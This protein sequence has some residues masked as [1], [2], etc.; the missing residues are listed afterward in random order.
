MRFSGFQLSAAALLG[1]VPALVQPASAQGTAITTEDATIRI[2]TV[3]VQ[4]NTVTVS[5]FLTRLIGRL[6]TGQVVFDQSYAAAFGS[7]AV[8]GALSSV[9][10]AIASEGGP[11]VVILS[12]VRTASQSTSST[13]SSSSDQT[14]SVALEPYT[15]ITFGP[16][17]ILIG[18]FGICATAGGI[19]NNLYVPPTGC[20]LPG[21]VYSLEVGETNFTTYQV[22]EDRITRTTTVT[23]T[24]SLNET[25]ELVGVVTPVGGVHAAL[26]REAGLSG[27]R[28]L[29]RL[30]GGPDGYPEVP[31]GDGEPLFNRVWLEAYGAWGS[32]DGAGDLSPGYDAN[33]WGVSAGLG[34]EVSDGLTLSLGVDVSRA[35]TE[36]VLPGDFPE[37][38]ESDLTQ[39]GLALHKDWGNAEAGLAVTYGFG[40][41]ETASGSGDLGGVSVAKTDA[42][43]WGVEGRVGVATALGGGTLTPFAGFAAVSVDFDDVTGSGSAF[44][45]FVSGDAHTSFQVFAGLS[46]AETFVAGQGDVTLKLSARVLQELGD[47]TVVLNAA[48]EGGGSLPLVL[49]EEGRTAGEVEAGLS[50]AISD[51]VSMHGGYEGRFSSGS[52]IHAAKAG[53]TVRF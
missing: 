51:N 41:F 25:Y 33:V 4:S 29:K 9:R 23:T 53:V 50:F 18:D 39:I 36:M 13:T 3:T 11:A 24:T 40:S 10:A 21:T 32:L 48:F 8:Q 37:S 27:E 2:Q 6:N 45:L 16:E 12:P 5:T 22:T 46:Y 30:T 26:V 43:L 17:D 34:H 20:S 35:D 52:D 44:D 42:A 15:R 31:E 38:G 47:E 19:V 14:I 28:F 7:G 1:L 49:A